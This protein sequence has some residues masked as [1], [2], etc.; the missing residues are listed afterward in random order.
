MT[1]AGKMAALEA[2]LLAE[3]GAARDL[4]AIERVR[5]AALGRK[6][7]LSELMARLSSLPVG[8]R[9]AFGQALNGLKARVGA[10]LEAKRSELE[11]GARATKLATERADVTLP[12][13]LGP[14]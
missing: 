8:E 11:R 1:D 10:E 4:A 13:R 12:V 14:L 7:R 6:G 5:V 3:I 9:R 2:A